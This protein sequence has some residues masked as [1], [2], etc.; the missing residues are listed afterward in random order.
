MEHQKSLPIDRVDAEMLNGD[1]MEAFR[2]ALEKNPAVDLLSVVGTRYLSAHRVGQYK[3]LSEASRLNF[4]TVFRLETE[5][6]A[7]P[8]INL[9]DAF[10]AE[11]DRLYR[12]ANPSEKCESLEMSTTTQQ[13]EQPRDW[14]RDTVEPINTAKIIYTL[15]AQAS[16]LLHHHLETDGSSESA[17]LAAALKDLILKSDRI[18]E[19]S[20]RT[21]AQLGWDLTE[22]HNLEYLAKNTPDLPIPKPHG[23]IMLG[24]VGAMF[25]SYFPGV[26]LKEVWPRLS[27]Q[28]KLSIQKQLSDIFSRLRSL[29]QEDGK[30]LGGVRGEGVKDYRIMEIFSYKG[31]TTARGFDELQFSAKHRASPCYVNLLRSFLDEDNKSL[32]GSVFTHGDLKKC[33]IMVEEDP[34]DTDAYVV[35]G[36]IDWEDGGFYPEY[37]ESTTLSNGQSIMSDDDWY[38]YTPH[39]ISPLRSPVRWLVDRLWGN[40][41]WSWRTDIVR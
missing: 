5:V 10:P 15:S 1:L 24:S 34:E 18:F 40:L 4:K 19:L 7:H 9:R 25:M 6:R 13:T 23:L 37:Y 30:E 32:Q 29:R 3:G 31:I 28:G 41:L 17:P 16:E 27:H 22:Y 14:L 2:Q 11:Y 39:C 12:W 26:T 38:L 20:I 21:G 35:S 36:I 8:E 33:N